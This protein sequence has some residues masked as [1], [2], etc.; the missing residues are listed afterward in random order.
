MA[1]K[2]DTFNSVPVMAPPRGQWTCS[3]GSR[4]E[5][6]V[7]VH[8]PGVLLRV[9]GHGPDAQLGAG[10]EHADGDLAWRER[11]IQTHDLELNLSLHTRYKL[12]WYKLRTE[13]DLRCFSGG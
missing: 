13:E 11:Q 9:D 3:R 6:A 2:S 10:P 12:G 1:V 5:P 8:L 4:V 7:P